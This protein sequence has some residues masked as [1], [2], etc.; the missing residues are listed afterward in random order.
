MSSVRYFACATDSALI[1]RQCPCR[2]EADSRSL[3]V[4]LL[5]HNRAGRGI[6]YI[7]RPAA[8]E[9]RTLQL[10]GDVPAVRFERDF[11]AVLGQVGVDTLRIGTGNPE[12]LVTRECRPASAGGRR[13]HGLSSSRIARI[14]AQ[15]AAPSVGTGM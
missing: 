5:G 6:N 8:V 10:V 1:A 7:V 4:I 2:V 3:L 14:S 12:S 11:D 15:S 9:R 13:C